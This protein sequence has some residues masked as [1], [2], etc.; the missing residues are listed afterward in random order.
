MSAKKRKW[1]K[2]KADNG[3]MFY[4]PK[5]FLVGLTGIYTFNEKPTKVYGGHIPF[6][7]S[8]NR[9][10][11]SDEIA[12]LYENPFVMFRPFRK[13]TLLWLLWRYIRRIL[14]NP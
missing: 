14:L 6:S 9:A 8:W 3:R 12:L 5:R 10:L 1:G 13:K 2:F 7:L 4:M 11:S